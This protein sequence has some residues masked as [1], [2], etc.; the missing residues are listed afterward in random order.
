MRAAVWNNEQRSVHCGNICVIQIYFKAYGTFNVGRRWI[1][2]K[3]PWKTF[4]R[5]YYFTSHKIVLLLELFCWVALNWTRTNSYVT[6]VPA[7]WNIF[8]SFCEFYRAIF[9]I[10]FF[11]GY[12]ELLLRILIIIIFLYNYYYI[13]LNIM[14]IIMNIKHILWIININCQC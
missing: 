4:E 6:I 11:F 3:S 13:F 9:D 8:Q 10:P 12:Y 2:M 5:R 7:T 1:Q 14:N